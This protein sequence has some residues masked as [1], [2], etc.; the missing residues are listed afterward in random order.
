M[1]HVNLE[2]T[3][4][5]AIATTANPPAELFD[6]GQITGLRDAVRKA[7]EGGA[8]AMVI[9]S[10]APLFSG[11][12][13]VALFHGQSQ[14]DGRDMLSDG[15]AMIAALEDAPFPIIAAVNGFC[16]AAGLE[17]ALA[18]D[19]IFAA[20]DTIF[21]QVEARIGVTTFLGGAYRLAE[22]CG[23]AIA[24]EIV[25]TAEHYSAE[26]FAQWH[27]V[28]RV[29]PAA[30]L[31]E[32]A[33]GVAKKIARGPAVAHTETKRLIRHALMH[34]SRSADRLVLDES[35]RLFETRDTQHAVG[36]LLEQGARKFMQNH[37]EIVFEGR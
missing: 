11:G 9:K 15:M 5:V 18:C 30:D 24:R 3:D 23:P 14:Q 4:D 26:Q 34:D 22:R 13:D 25:Y 28:N 7:T 21:S 27:I 8:R 12:A 37:H 33:V 35:T 32:T 36:L 1:S 16:F 29:V 19:F 31:H 17:V 2:M 6:V 20:D 10:D